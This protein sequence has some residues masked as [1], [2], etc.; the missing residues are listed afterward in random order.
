[1]ET[2]PKRNDKQEE[3]HKDRCECAHYFCHHN[4][5]DAERRKTAEEQ[6]EVEPDAKDGE[7]AQ[8]P[9]P[10][11]KIIFING[12]VIDGITYRKDI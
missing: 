3:Y 12:V 5:V 1:M 8:L 2:Q 4:N 11:L 7:G 10:G 9:L 6:K